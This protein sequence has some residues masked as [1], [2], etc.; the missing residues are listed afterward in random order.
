MNVSSFANQESSRVAML[1]TM[2]RLESFHGGKYILYIDF[3]DSTRTITTKRADIPFVFLSTTRR[4]GCADTQYPGVYAEA[5]AGYDFIRQIVCQESKDAKARDDFQ[6]SDQTSGAAISPSDSSSTSGGSASGGSGSKGDDDF[7][8]DDFGFSFGEAGNS[9][10]F[11]A[12][13]GGG[14]GKP[15]S[16]GGGGGGG[17]DDGGD[18]GGGGSQG[19]G[20]NFGQGG[21]FG[22]FGDSSS[23]SLA[24][25]GTWDDYLDDLGSFG[26]SN[27]GDDNSYDDQYD[28]DDGQYW[29]GSSSGSSFVGGGGGGHHGGHGGGGGGHHGGHGGGGGW[30]GSDWEGS[31]A[32]WWA[33]LWN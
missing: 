25:Q 31:I 27:A 29:G 16:F 28:D 9:G 26:G 18:G 12:G 22:G 4:Y 7:N 2:Y 21:N 6:C 15:D 17:D 30:W 32:S 5:S 3:L 11:G 23:G 33:G 1:R 24:S 8:Y 13:G 14:G 20:G 10:G 19:S